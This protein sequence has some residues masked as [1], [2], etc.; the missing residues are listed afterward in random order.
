MS[1]G[2]LNIKENMRAGPGIIFSEGKSY[3]DHGP[4]YI[5]PHTEKMT[6]K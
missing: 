1:D 5:D 6:L 2:N 3:V 4:H